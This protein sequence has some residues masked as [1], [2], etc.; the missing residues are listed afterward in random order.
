MSFDV[1]DQSAL[2]RAV[3]DAWDRRLRL[4][5][6]TIADEDGDGYPSFDVDRWVIEVRVPLTDDEAEAAPVARVTAFTVRAPDEVDEIVEALQTSDAAG[7]Y[8]SVVTG[9]DPNGGP[10]VSLFAGAA[11]VLERDDLLIIDRLQV[12]TGFED[13]PHLVPAI[14]SAVQ[15]GPAG[16]TAAFVLAD[17]AQWNVPLTG[18]DLEAINLA[19]WA[20]TGV[21]VGVNADPHEAHERA[22]DLIAART[23][24]DAPTPGARHGDTWVS[25]ILDRAAEEPALAV[26]FVLPPALPAHI[27]AGAPGGLLQVD[28]D[29]DTGTLTIQTDD[30]EFEVVGLP[31]NAP[32]L[33]G[34]AV[35][36]SVQTQA[37]LRAVHERWWTYQPALHDRAHEVIDQFLDGSLEL[38]TEDSE[39]HLHMSNLELNRSAWPL[40]GELSV[41]PVRE[42]AEPLVLSVRLDEDGILESVGAIIVHE[43]GQVKAFLHDEWQ[44]WLPDHEPVLQHLLSLGVEEFV[45]GV[46]HDELDAGVTGAILTGD[47]DGH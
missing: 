26:P 1:P 7:S 31:G 15:N 12:E 2:V 33:V 20:D 40:P 23:A 8:S 36:T 19:Q 14:V 43:N 18:D 29:P 44:P 10:F 32:Q 42:D 17:P 39:P 35:G 30:G 4:V 11:E 28:A 46:L 27:W 38:A 13:L 25:E 9:T 3:H 45:V 34:A 22:S 21:L 47:V 41:D 16:R 5:H 24:E 6:I 37:W